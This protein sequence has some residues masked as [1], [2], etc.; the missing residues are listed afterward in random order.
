MSYSSEEKQER[1]FRFR[2]STQKELDY[3]GLAGDGEIEDTMVTFLNPRIVP[4]S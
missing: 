1:F 2:L 3:W 4:Q